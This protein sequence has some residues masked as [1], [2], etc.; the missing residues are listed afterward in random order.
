MFPRTA[1]DTADL[2][3]SEFSKGNTGFF[4]PYNEKL[5]RLGFEDFCSRCLGRR[6]NINAYVDWSR[7]AR[8]L[9]IPRDCF[10]HYHAEHHSPFSD[11]MKEVLEHGAR[12]VPE[13][14]SLDKFA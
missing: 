5:R 3:R 14:V 7:A 1:G 4:P 9:L 8:L 6:D 10:V 11:Y 12:P 13:N 2:W